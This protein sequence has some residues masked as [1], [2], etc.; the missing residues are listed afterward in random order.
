MM[1]SGFSANSYMDD[2][3]MEESSVVDEVY[4]DIDKKAAK[5]QNLIR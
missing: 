1:A 2:S 3:P 5:A 4:N